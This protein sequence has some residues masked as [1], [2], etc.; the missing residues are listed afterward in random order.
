MM[1]HKTRSAALFILVILLV[2]ACAPADSANSDLTE[3]DISTPTLEDINDVDPEDE[4]PAPIIDAE[5]DLEDD[6]AGNDLTADLPAWFEVPLKDVRTDQEFTI[7]DHLG[8]VILVETMAMWCSLCLRQQIQVKELHEKISDQTN[9]I[10]LGLD[11]DVNERAEDLKAY[12]ETH[13]FDWLYAIS[14]AEVSLEISELYGAQFLNPP[15]TP[16]LVIDAN[17]EVH[18]TPFGI[19]SAD[20]LYDFITPFLAE[21]GG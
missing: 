2:S 3:N 12:T 7:K 10:S 8:K 13:G 5:S 1:N 14:P 9:F 20:E 4:E 11:I 17:G 15:S 6:D 21:A 19:K 16:I 18:L